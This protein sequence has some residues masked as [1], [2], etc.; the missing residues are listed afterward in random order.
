MIHNYLPRLLLV[1]FVLCSLPVRADEPFRKHRYSSFQVLP[2]CNDGDIVFIGNSITNM[3]NW[4]EAFGSRQNIHGRGNSGGFTQEILDNL[5]AMIAGNPSKVFLMIGTNDLG[6]SG[7]NYTPELVSARIQKILARIRSE[8]PDA[9]VY[10][11]SILPSLNGIRTKVKTETTNQLVK[12]WMEQRNDPQLVY[13]DIYSLLAATDGSLN[14][15][16]ASQ[17]AT[18]VSYDGLHLTQKGYRIWMKAI[19]EHVGY[20]CVYPATAD[21]L[22]GGLTYSNGMR[23]TYFGASPVKSTDILLIGDEMIHNGE[24]HELLGSA[25]FK[26]RGIGWGYPSVKVAEVAGTFDAILSGNTANGVIKEAPRAVCLYAGLSDVTAGSN[27]A[28]IFASYSNAVNSL[29]GKLPETPLFIMTVLPFPSA[30]TAQANTIT[31]LNASLRTLA[32]DENKIYI[33]DSYGATYGTSRNET[34]FMGTGNV[35]LSGFGYARVAQEIAKTINE[36]LGTAYQALSDRE[37]QKNMTRFAVRTSAYATYYEAGTALGT[38]DVQALSDYR[39]TVAQALDEVENDDAD[40]AAIQS[41]L[42]EAS[43]VVKTALVLP[44]ADNA[45][46]GHEFRLFTPNRGNYYLTSAGAG[47]AVTSTAKNNY[48]DS[49]WQLLPR[50]DGNWNIRNVADQSYLS[51]TAAASARITTVADEPSSGWEFSWCNGNGL[52][53]IQ[54][55][56]VQLHQTAAIGKVTNWSSTGKGG[57]RADAGCQFCIEDV[58]DIEADVKEPVV[59][60]GGPFSETVDKTNGLLYRN[61]EVSTGFSSVWKST[62]GLL[63]FSAGANNMQWNGDRIDARSGQSGVSGYTLSCDDGYIITGFT[64]TITSLTASDVQNWTINDRNFT[65]ASN[66]DPQTVTFDNINSSVVGMSLRGSNTGT[67]IT[68]FTV[69]LK[70]RTPSLKIDLQNGRLTGNTS[71]A[72]TWTST[73]SEPSVELFTDINPAT[74]QR[75]NNMAANGTELAL[76]RGNSTCNYHI[77]TLSDDYVIT[78]YEFDFTCP[79]IPMTVTPFE[80]GAAVTGTTSGTAHVCVTGLSAE[81]TGFTLSGDGNKQICTSNFYVHFKLVDP[82]ATANDRFV[83]FKN[84]SSEGVP[85]RI[86]AIAKAQNGD[87]VAVADYRY[88]GADIGMATN[89]KLDLRFRIKDHETGEWGEVQTLAAARGTGSSNIAFG[90]PC[91][92]ADRES[93]RIMVTSCCGNVSFPGGTHDNH[94]GWARFY[95]EDGGYTWSDYTDISQQ[96]FDQLDLRSDGKIRCFFIGSGKITQSTTVKKAQ[97]YRLYCAALVKVNDGTNTNYVFYSDDFGGNWHLLGTPDDC[98]IPSG[99]DEPKAEELPD[100]SVL[101]SSRI[102]G[103]RYYNIFHFTDV[104]AG[105]GSWGQMATSGSS[106][107][108]I[109][110]SSNACNGETMCLPVERK[111]DGKKMFILLQSVPFGPSDRSH[112]GINYKELADLND[113]RTPDGLAKDWDGRKQVTTLTSAYSTMTLDADNHI[114]FFYEENGQGAGYDMV[115]KKYSVEEITDSAYTYVQLTSADSTAYMKEALNAYRMEDQFGSYVGQYTQEA[116]ALI[117]AARAYYDTH[118]GR[119]GYAAFNATLNTAPC[120]KVE[121]NKLYALRNYGRSTAANKYVMTA[122]QNYFTGANEANAPIDNDA[123]LFLFM[124]TE[125]DEVFLFYHPASQRYYG[126]LG[127][128]EKETAHTDSPQNAGTFRIESNRYGM[129]ALNNLNHTGGNAYI[130]LAGDLVRL[131]PWR[132]TEPSLWYIIPVKQVPDA[133]DK[134][135]ADNGVP[136]VVYDLAGRRVKKTSQKG[137][138]I[139]DGGKRLIR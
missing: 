72:G 137:I 34:C 69:T 13:L 75:T 113:F 98:P 29:R 116:K 25:D 100:G 66:S 102:G 31:E 14:G 64:M 136:A 126:R 62:D 74:G 37:A 63:N 2:A 1:L 138:Y 4:Y 27:A 92:V 68:G 101:V 67:L 51:P 55:G 44:S 129:S 42:N 70:S 78:G 111:A 135:T 20:E 124:P 21:N 46:E 18:S 77:A 89:G 97:Y 19:E 17:S 32:S 134:V 30:S 22:W 80:S 59:I 45:G 107:N 139:V 90:D 39:A 73:I 112:V 131:V 91:I 50:T 43:A 54:S 81:S 12:T 76:Y 122:G 114:A 38:Y 130:H 119:E 8:V 118:P 15:N 24:W 35:Y 60:P 83:V 28:T 110:A 79:A 127:A 40:V 99:A 88:S 84:P 115:Y 41:R 71:F 123:R 36:K 85:Y 95:S 93:N 106:N 23:V 109:T 49:R 26:D 125:E 87:L 108:G 5:E 121:A 61:G 96:V 33:I 94:Q 56:T 65:T 132:A 11:Q 105:E 117:D 128:N 47:V 52:Y 82:S 53:I 48:T 7:D 16:T 6:A 9:T 103:G 58:S 104:L 57:D 120:V 3:M 86:P 10:Y 133:I